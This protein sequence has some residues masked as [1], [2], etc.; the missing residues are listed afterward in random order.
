MVFYSTGPDQRA[1]RGVNGVGVADLIRE[2][3]AA[4]VG[5]DHA[6][7]ASGNP[8]AHFNVSFGRSPAVSRARARGARSGDLPQRPASGSLVRAPRVLPVMCSATAR[9]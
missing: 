5:C 7:V 6:D 4:T 2:V 3:G 9:R 8:N 1:G